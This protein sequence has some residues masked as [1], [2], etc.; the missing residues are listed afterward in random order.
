M[1]VTVLRVVCCVFY[2]RMMGYYKSKATLWVAITCR[3]VL[4]YC[5]VSLVS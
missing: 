4:S 2:M 5:F 1:C 3:D